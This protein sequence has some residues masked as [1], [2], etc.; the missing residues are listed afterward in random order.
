[1]MF[2]ARA[3]KSIYRL[4]TYG[5]PLLEEGLVLKVAFAESFVPIII[6]LIEIISR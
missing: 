6:M 5:D 2:V 4:T 1:M 3:W